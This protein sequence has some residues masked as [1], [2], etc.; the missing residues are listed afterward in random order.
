MKH[1]LLV[2]LVSLLAFPL[3]AQEPQAPQGGGGGQAPPPAPEPAPQPQPRQPNAN[4]FPQPTPNVQNDSINIRGRIIT[5]ARGL[6]S[7]I[8]EVKFESE[9]GQP[10]GF[11]YANSDGEFTFQRNGISFDQTIYVVVNVEGY[12]PYRDRIFGG[13][14]R[15][16]FDGFLNIFL[17]REATTVDRSGATI[18]DL[19]Q[20]RAK[21]PGKAVDEYEKA[22]KESSKGNRSK[23]VD[24]LQRA[25]KLAPD[26]Y[27]A[28]HSLALQYIA[29]EKYDDAENSLTRARDLSPKAAEPLINLGTLYYQ[30]GESQAE[31]GHAEEADVTYNKAADFLEE[32]IR[33]N[34]LYASAHGYLGAT[35]YKL[36]EYE[37]A[38]ESLKRSLELDPDQQN[39]RL[40]LINVYTKAARYSDALEQINL[41]LNKSPK[42][43]QRPTLE[44]IKQQIE[45]ALAK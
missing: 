7:S 35:L 15:G 31:A 37:K 16:D 23:A 5:G 13:F 25:I 28:H 11:A 42:A 2:V 4:P 1:G 3:L 27:E 20:L 33:R 40:M 34:P 43:P 45:K 44:N 9:G 22:L 19:K 41:F 24:G 36:A 30:R 18:V 29:L 21:I 26:F 6:D 12:K 10:L 38:E 8:T 14:S 32:A 39:P 17:D